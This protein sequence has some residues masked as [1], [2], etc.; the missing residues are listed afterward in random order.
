[1]KKITSLFVWLAFSTAF[2][3]LTSCQSSGKQEEKTEVATTEKVEAK[4]TQIQSAIDSI[5]AIP[6]SVK[7]AEVVPAKVSAPSAKL[8]AQETTLKKAK[9]L[10]KKNDSPVKPKKPVLVRPQLPVKRMNLRSEVSFAEG[11]P[12]DL[13]KQVTTA[14]GL[15]LDK[16]KTWKGQPLARF[17]LTPEDVQQGV[18]RS[19]ILLKPDNEA[20]VKYGWVM[21][22]PKEYWEPSDEFDIVMQLHGYDDKILGEKAR[23]PQFALHVHKDHLKVTIHHSD[24]PVNTNKND[25]DEKFDLG[26]LPKDKYLEMVLE[27]KH[28]YDPD[29]YARLFINGKKVMDYKGGTSF[30]DLRKYPYFKAGIYNRKVQ[31]PRVVYISN[32]RHGN[33]KS[34]Y[35]DVAP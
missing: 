4:Q 9:P 17:E 29:G 33:S 3:F 7:T 25:M 27:I 1:M 5:P 16:Q 34:S 35:K 2:G 8:A 14:H 28:S 30:N 10:R 15:T 23:N 13:K 26:P 32:I 21:Y 19:E 11:I 18:V 6:D 22:F 24:L 12:E 31:L 20:E